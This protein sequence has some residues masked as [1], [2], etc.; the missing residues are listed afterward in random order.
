MKLRTVLVL[1]VLIVGSLFAGL[2]A[3]GH[4]ILQG[5]IPNILGR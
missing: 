5:G 4:R 1:A 2:P 3:R